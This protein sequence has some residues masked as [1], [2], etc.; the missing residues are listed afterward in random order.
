MSVTGAS[1]QHD[2]AR[3]CSLS[4]LADVRVHPHRPKNQQRFVEDL[5]EN[6]LFCVSGVVPAPLPASVHALVWLERADVRP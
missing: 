4:D 6:S 2:V 1:S 5:P 3:R